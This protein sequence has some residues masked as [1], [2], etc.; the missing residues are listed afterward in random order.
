MLEKKNCH[1]HLLCQAFWYSKN[2]KWSS[3][4]FTSWKKFSKSDWFLSFWLTSQ[5]IV[6]VINISF[7]CVFE[8]LNWFWCRTSRTHINAM[9]LSKK[10]PLLPS[11]PLNS[12]NQGTSP[13]NLFDSPVL[14]QSSS[15]WLN[16]SQLQQYFLK[17]GS[18][19]T[20]LSITLAIGKSGD[21]H[22]TSWP[23]WH[24]SLGV[25]PRHSAH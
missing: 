18:L 3:Y 23:Y 5:K 10:S 9:L 25:A 14:W 20:Y 7:S 12:R 24:E 19:A 2:H 8:W 6:L 17:K 16:S 15:L 1:M 13:T 22:P 21:L 11:Q 4:H